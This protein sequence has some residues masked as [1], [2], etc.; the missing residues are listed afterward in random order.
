[1]TVEIRVPSP[2]ESI[3]EVTIAAWLK[4]DGEPVEADEEI[5]ELESEKATLMVAA[6]AAGVLRVAAAAGSTL[7]VGA[8]AGHIEADGAAPPTRPSMAEAAALATTPAS[9]AIAP[10][11][12]AAGAPARSPA[13]RKLMAERG[14]TPRQV[15]GSGPGGRITKDDVQ[16]ARDRLADAPPTPAAAPVSAAER[17][18][19]A[20]TRRETRTTVSTLRQKL[21]ERLVAVRRET[22]M[23]TTFNEADL[24]AVMALRAAWRERFRELHQVDLGI[25]SFFAAAAVRALQEFP[26]VNSRLEGTEL[27]EPG[28]VDLGIAVSAPKGLVVPVIRDAQD[29]GFEG[30]EEEIARLAARARENRITIEEMTGGTFTISN[31]GVFGS[32][33]STPILNPPQCAIL[34]LHAIQ[35]RPVAVA[36]RVEIRPMM[37]LALSYDHRL[38]DGRESV[39]F[40]KRI[41]ELVEEPVRLLLKV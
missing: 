32:L 14:L 29:K 10:E 25:M 34:G 39:G 41:K 7:A 4:G 33:L 26:M 23:L 40:L 15:A 19:G 21:A 24:G 18:A 36:G 3:Q 22:A 38:I 12:P 2:G 20:E 9:T 31:G 13:A 35:D 27:V 5:L 8:V 16:T 17:T 28:Y 37:Y 30:L 1:M 6:P 11:G